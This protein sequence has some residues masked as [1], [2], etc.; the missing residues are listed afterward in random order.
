MKMVIFKSG[1]GYAVT[2][3]TNYY[4]YIQD[5]HK[6]Q[7]FGSDWTVEEIINYYCQYCRCVREDFEFPAY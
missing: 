2:P 6:I 4:A 5:A 1:D 3:K 7:Y